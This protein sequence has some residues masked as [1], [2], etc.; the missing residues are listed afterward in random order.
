[1]RTRTRP[2]R[3]PG[4]QP[5]YS[6]T[7]GTSGPLLYTLTDQE[8]ALVQEFSSYYALLDTAEHGAT[9]MIERSSRRINRAG[10]NDADTFEQALERAR[11]GW[12]ENT[13]RLREL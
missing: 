7:T 1:M 3:S 5:Q 11:C 9:E 13:R 12:P 8:G 6:S 10:F 2:R 4:L